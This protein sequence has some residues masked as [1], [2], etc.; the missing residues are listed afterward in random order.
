MVLLGIYILLILY[1]FSWF[2]FFSGSDGYMDQLAETLNTPPDSNY[3]IYYCYNCIGSFDPY[4]YLHMGQ[5]GQLVEYADGLTDGVNATFTE[6][7][8][9]GHEY[10][11]WSA[12]LTNFL[13]VAFSLPESGG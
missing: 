9:V 8:N 7:L 6:I 2:G 4:F 12:G 13:S 5:Y 1:V 11:A 10:A 3:P